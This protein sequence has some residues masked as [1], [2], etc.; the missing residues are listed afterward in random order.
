[1]QQGYDLIGDIHG[2][3]ET[4]IK[5][6][7]QMGYS[8]KNGVYQHPKRKALFLGDIVD[9]GPHI[10]LACHVVRDMVD[11]GYAD[12][13]MGNH[14]YNLVTYLT[15]AP[16]GIRRPYLRPHT[17]RNT[18]I[19]EQ[20]LEQFAN[21]PHEFNEFLDWFLTIPL[22]REYENFR[23]VHACW[24]LDM[25]PEYLERYGTN[26]ITKDMLAESVQTDSFL[27]QFLDRI[28]RGT[29][30]RLPDGRSITS[31]DGMVR[32]FFRA[33]FWEMDPQHYQDV[34]FQPDPLPQ[35][36]AYGLLSEDEKNQLLYY[37]PEEKPLFI[38]HYWMSGLPAPIMPNIAC[39]DY[40]AVKYGRLAAYRMDSETALQ[41]N[42]FTWIKVEKPERHQ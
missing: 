35:D 18:F 12:I 2:C 4:L 8:K 11:G 15:E 28:L 42:K 37:G 40:S 33:K 29:S 21:Y 6:L 3:G 39:L 7:E 36:I 17:P 34:V 23:V 19:V 26:M 31:K 16:P 24:D 20:T 41:T 22:F 27:Y 9:R 25:I 14:E 38:G 10:R 32:K 30:L 13:V 1:M 5:L